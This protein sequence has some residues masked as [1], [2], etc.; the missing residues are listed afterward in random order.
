MVHTCSSKGNLESSIMQE[1]FNF[2]LKGRRLK[3]LGTLFLQNGNKR[4]SR[5]H[6]PEHVEY[7]ASRI[8]SHQ[9]VGNCHILELGIFGV[10]EV[11]FWFPDSLHQIWI[12]QVQWL[13]QLRMVEAWIKPMLSEIKIYL[14]VLK[15]RMERYLMGVC[16]K[17]STNL[18]QDRHYGVGDLHESAKF[19][20]LQVMFHF[21]LLR[22]VFSFFASIRVLVSMFS[23][24]YLLWII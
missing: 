12:I 22:Y 15:K 20:I 3:N 16:W 5:N 2:S 7:V 4:R 24:F 14:I 10:G 17:C 8:N 11:D 19:K 18:F 23:I 13:V 1:N 6:L 9:H 21:H